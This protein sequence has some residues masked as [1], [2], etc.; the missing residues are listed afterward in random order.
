MRVSEQYFPVVLFIMLYKPV[1]TFESVDEI[2]KWFLLL[3]LW[4]KTS[5]M[6][7]TAQYFPMVL[8][9]KLYK[10]VLHLALKG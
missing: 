5:Q 9:I 2:L 7:A 1:L 3:S 6:K 4:M 10:T 8:F